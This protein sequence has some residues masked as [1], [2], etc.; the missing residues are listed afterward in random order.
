MGQLVA[1]GAEELPAG[2]ELSDRTNQSK[3]PID[4]RAAN[5]WPPVERQV[6]RHMA[7]AN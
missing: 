4:V 1:A 2:T 6:F 3:P 5:A 7:G